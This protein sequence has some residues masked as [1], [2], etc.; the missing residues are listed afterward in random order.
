MLI[1]KTSLQHWQTWTIIMLIQTSLQHGQHKSR[2]WSGS[3]F[4]ALEMI[5]SVTKQKSGVNGMSLA[6]WNREGSVQDFHCGQIITTI[7][8]Y[9][10]HTL[11]MW[12]KVWSICYCSSLLNSRYFNVTSRDTGVLT[13]DTSLQDIAIE[14]FHRSTVFSGARVAREP[15]FRFAISFFL[16]G[17]IF[18]FSVCF[19]F[20]TS[21][22]R[23][24]DDWCE[25]R[26]N[27]RV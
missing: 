20:F 27:W 11:K 16:S 5:F 7:T 14:E 26:T 17:W 4:A 15:S 18:F 25:I 6:K 23:R 10:F 1:Q 12:E 8:N 2:N 13:M 3:D 19:S 24:V 9:A 21:S 22:P